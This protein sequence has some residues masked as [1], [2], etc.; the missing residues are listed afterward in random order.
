MRAWRAAPNSLVSVALCRRLGWGGKGIVQVNHA[1]PKQWHFTSR[2][3]LVRREEATSMANQVLS[4]A[5]AVAVPRFCTGVS[6]W[7][8]CGRGGGALVLVV[9]GGGHS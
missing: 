7:V 3:L 4:Q 2:P 5:E 6:V 8:T 9:G 1:R